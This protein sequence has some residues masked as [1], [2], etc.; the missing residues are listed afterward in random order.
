M[1]TGNGKMLIAVE[2][3]KI[4]KLFWP[5]VNNFQNMAESRLGVFSFEENSVSWLDEW[6]TTQQYL[7]DSNILET[8]AKKG[9]LTISI[10]DF[11]LPLQDCVVR[12]VS[13]NE[14][15]AVY[16][17][18]KTQLGENQKKD[19][20]IFEGSVLHKNK[21]AA[22]RIFSPDEVKEHD[23]GENINFDSPQERNAG[24]SSSMVSFFTTPANNGETHSVNIFI[25]ISNSVK[26]TN[27][28]MTNALNTEPSKW[29]YKTQFHWKKWL[30]RSKLTDPK[31]KRALLNMKT[32]MDENHGGFAASAAARYSWIRDSVYAAYAF[33]LAGYHSEAS[34]FYAWLKTAITKHKYLLF[35]D[36]TATSNNEKRTDQLATAVWGIYS[37]Y[38]KTND[39]KFLT[40][41]WNTVRYAAEELQKNFNPKT[42]LMS[43]SMTPWED[44]F[45][46]NAYTASSSCS[47]FGAAA[48]MAKKLGHENL[49]QEWLTVAEKLKESYLFMCSDETYHRAYNEKDVD[50]YM[51]SMLVPFNMADTWAEKTEKTIE[52]IEKS[53]WD[54]GLKRNSASSK[55]CFVSTAWLAWVHKKSGNMKKYRIIMDMIN[56]NFTGLGVPS[57]AAE[58][59]VSLWPNAMYVIARMD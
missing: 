9:R 18:T 55:A 20:V 6:K 41:M 53:L 10:K 32:L 46:V 47:A 39:A 31:G 25:A 26:N 36:G 19:S 12:M 56:E 2:N 40:S 43:P 30:E 8:T 29:L 48:A 5:T 38:T 22:L 54:N 23:M 11:A 44:S 51:L 27:R 59:D 15:S 58:N 37:H 24:E 14:P 35:A 50:S 49:S 57:T 3:G 21:K 34:K 33:D 13:A 4:T 28:V 16:C 1:I 17:Y 42:G 52:K 45:N 7:Q